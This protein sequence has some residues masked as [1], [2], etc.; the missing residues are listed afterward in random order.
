MRGGGVA[1]G[2][3]ERVERRGWPGAQLRSGTVGRYVTRGAG[4]DD[5]AAGAGAGVAAVVGTGKVRM[6][7]D[8]GAA[9]TEASFG[10]MVAVGLQLPY[11]NSAAHPC[12]HRGRQLALPHLADAVD[13]LLVAPPVSPSPR[14]NLT[15]YHALH[16][17][18]RT[19]PHFP[20]SLPRPH[21]PHRRDPLHALPRRVR[22]QPLHAIVKNHLERLNPSSPCLRAHAAPA[23]S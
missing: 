16:R 3:G 9:F 22:G 21:I 4:G 6:L 2:V 5:D 15:P 14:G 1:D 17:P 7:G 18:S 23:S 19:P 8:V 11:Q 13:R 10:G 20:S 12:R